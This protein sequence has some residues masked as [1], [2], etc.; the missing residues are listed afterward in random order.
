VV[1]NR[2]VQ[3]VTV[4]VEAMRDVVTLIDQPAADLAESLETIKDFNLD[5]LL[6]KLHARR[7]WSA[8]C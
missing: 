8:P 3:D 7:L 5:G 6:P 4:R 2:A 1:Y